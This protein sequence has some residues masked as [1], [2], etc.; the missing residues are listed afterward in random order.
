MGVPGV[1]QIVDVQDFGPDTLPGTF[2]LAQNDNDSI[3]LYC[4]A[5]N[6]A[7]VVGITD[8][9]GNHYELVRAY[10]SPVQGARSEIWKAVG[11]AAAAPGANTFTIQWS[12]GDNTQCFALELDPCDVD[13]GATAAASSPAGDA[14]LDTGPFETRLPNGLILAYLVTDMSAVGAGPGAG[15]TLLE[16]NA[17]FQ[18]A[19]E[20]A[21]AVAPGTYAATATGNV[22]DPWDILSAVWAPAPASIVLPQFFP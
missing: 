14:A 4:L 16:Q 19:I 21:P 1:V 15:F 22:L 11:I 18:F 8:T 6:G 7:S 10:Q 9:S 2:A 3:A 5:G 20:S 13:A 12:G 17:F